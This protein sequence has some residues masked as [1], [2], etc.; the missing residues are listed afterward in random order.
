ME[1]VQGKAGDDVSCASTGGQQRD[2]EH[3]CVRRA[4]TF[5]VWEMGNNG[6]G[7]REYVCSWC[8]GCE[9]VA[10]GTGVKDG[11]SFDGC[12]ISIDHLEKD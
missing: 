4:Y 6:H 3:A 12:G 1:Q 8:I 2:V 7:S 5:T 9:E 10:C 11:P